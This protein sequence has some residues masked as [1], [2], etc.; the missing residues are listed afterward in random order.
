[1]LRTLHPADRATLFILAVVT[2]TLAVA[3]AGGAPVAASL[4]LHAGILVAFAGLATW[5]GA[6]EGAVVRGIAIIAVMFTLY[7]TL[8]H[9]AFAAVPWLADPWLAAADRALL[10]GRSPSLVVEPLGATRWAEV[11]SFGYAMFIPYL[12]VSIV[13]S[14]VGRPPAERDEFVTGFAVLYALSFLGYLFLPA[15]GPVVWMAGDFT[16]PIHGGTFHRII[17]KSVESV[18]GPHGAFPSLHVGASLYATLF[19]LRHRNP[20]RALIY[21]PLVATIALATLVLRYHYAVDLAAAVV[22]A[23]AASHLARAAM[24]RRGETARIAAEGAAEAAA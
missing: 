4:G 3:A 17:L 2:A 1:M 21:L 20:L 23:L 10:L 11:L 12:Y 19:D 15:R 8:G 18:G 13:L 24:A 16:L 14:L 5:M 6:R 22:L 9:V 7:S